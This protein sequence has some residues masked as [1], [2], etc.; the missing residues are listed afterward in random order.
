MRATVINKSDDKGWLVVRTD[1]LSFMLISLS[2]PAA[3]HGTRDIEVGDILSSDF[4]PES[5]ICNHTRASLVRMREVLEHTDAP[6]PLY[7]YL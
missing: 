6:E 4:L 3:G 7:A 2:S 5:M 1:Y